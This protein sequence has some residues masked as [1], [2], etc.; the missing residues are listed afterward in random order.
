MNLGATSAITIVVASTT[1]DQ[2]AVD[3]CARALLREVEAVDVVVW[4]GMH[5][6]GQD[7]GP[8]DALRAHPHLVAVTADAAGDRGTLYAAG[9]AAARTDHVVFTD[10][11]TEVGAGWRAALGA[12][13][14]GGSVV[15]GGPVRCSE[16]RT[17]RSAAGFVVEYGPHAAPP[18]HSAGGDVAANNVAYDR[19]V[20]LGVVGTGAVWKSAVDRNLAKR[21]IVPT[22]CP[23]MAVTSRKR[24]DV[25]DLTW[26]RACH[27]RHFGAARAAEW[28]RG[29]RLLAAAGCALLPGLAWLR[30]MRRAWGAG[31][32]GRPLRRAGTLVPLALA[33]WSVG[34]AAGY[35]TARGPRSPV[36]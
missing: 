22:I 28:G 33:S 2:R 35:L 32:L 24:Y 20:L 3:R 26:E 30:L 31:S 18:Y 11:V 14:R 13:L 15:L 7:P 5:G 19:S 21:G 23:E 25:R 17:R 10:S 36:F 8:P 4:V 9:L 16:P 6:S 1:D 34:E 29:R 27:G 12:S